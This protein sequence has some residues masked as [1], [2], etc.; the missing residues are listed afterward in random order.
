MNITVEQAKGNVPVTILKLQGELDASSYLEVINKAKEIY[1][2]GTENLLLD[3]S[4]LSFMASSGL[5]ALHSVALVMRGEEPPD[6]ESGWSAFHAIANEVEGENKFEKHLKLLNPQP[7]VAR[8]LEIAGF[9]NIIEVF[10][11]KNSAINSF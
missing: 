11:D 6:P 4:Q 8:T 9:N 3:M 5:V 10:T 2:D 7:R 1:D